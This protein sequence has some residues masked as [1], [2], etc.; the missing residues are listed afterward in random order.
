MKLLSKLTTREK[1]VLL[2][3][4]LVAIALVS[5]QIYL[6]YGSI[7]SSVKEY[8][9]AKQVNLEKQ[10]SRLS[11]KEPLK[12]KLD[13]L[14]SE[15]K[16]LEQRLLPGDK[17]PVAQAELQR[18]LKET[19]LSSGIEIKLERPLSPV[20]MELYTAVPVEIGFTA[21]TAKLKGMLYKIKTSPFLLTVTEMKSNVT[22]INN[23]VDT[24]T[25]LV[26]N[27]FIK[28][29]ANSKPKSVSKKRTGSAS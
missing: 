4:G 12:K 15:L 29:P 3:G 1:R 28:K 13:A 5:Y 9:E 25:T 16:G 23:P 27:G 10:L 26:V 2:I 14:N 21:T 11:E 19:A 8:A 17:P 7:R 6:W 20:E 22:N 24:Y 18:I